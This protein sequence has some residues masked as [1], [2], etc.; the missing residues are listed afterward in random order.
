MPSGSMSPT[1]NLGDY[2]LSKRFAY[3]RSAP[4][5]GDFIVFNFHDRDGIIEYAKRIVGLPGDRVRL[6][7]GIVYINGTP[8]RLTRISDFKIDCDLGPCRN[9]P[10]FV[11]TLTGGG[12]HRIVQTTTDGPLDDMDVVTVPANSYFVLG[13]NRDNSNDSRVSLGFI[14]ASD[15]VGKAVIKYIDGRSHHWVWEPIE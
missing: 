15:I 5:R 1:I 7:G 4:L 14:A 13:D 11:E 3:A 12:P 10:Q 9:A 8:P 2:F 6:V